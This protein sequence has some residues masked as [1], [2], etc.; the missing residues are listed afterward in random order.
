V[1]GFLDF[2][3][4][5]A[6]SILK[7]IMFSTNIALAFRLVFFKF[8]SESHPLTRSK[9]VQSPHKTRQLVFLL[10]VHTL[11]KLDLVADHSCPFAES[12]LWGS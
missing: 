12:A 11:A 2:V 3:S 6:N 7:Q 1:S 10:N 4:I 9:A 8:F 5:G